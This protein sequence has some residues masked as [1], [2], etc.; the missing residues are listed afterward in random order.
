M[1]D[2][3]ARAGVDKATVSRALN[4]ETRHHVSAATASRVE[5]AAR[6]LGYVPNMLAR[7]LRR[8]ASMTVGVLLPDI[9]NPI[10]P[11]IVRGIESQLSPRH[12]TAL[13]TNTDGR[14]DLEHAA[15][16]SLLARRVDGFL[17]ATGRVGG[18][19]AHE[20]WE[21]RIPAI[22]VNRG[23]P[24]VPYPVVTGADA[25]GVVDTVDHL[26]QLGHRRLLHVAGPADLT[27]SAIR[28]TA[29]LAACAARGVVA[30]VVEAEAISIPA[31]E[32]LAARE[33]DHP[34]GA[35]A[36]VTANDLLA[37]GVLRVMRSRGLE[38]P[39]DLSVTGFNDNP[40]AEDAFV[41]LTTVRVPFHTMGARAAGML[42]ERIHGTAEL[43]A[44][45]TT[46]P[47][48][49]VIRGS[50]GPAPEIRPR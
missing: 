35:T 15:Y 1:S 24:G 42:V 12:Y 43:S 22:L 28:R 36:I 49:L 33:L 46:L 27:T 17:I 37:L 18:R 13:V 41:P 21:Q 4:A 47:V 23:V 8:S 34:S 6:E 38:C 7:G 25:D 39:R 44:P 31:G 19:V 40:F 50:T 2:V 11:P 26:V 48:S 16:S 5:S 3:A 29:F 14:D 9:T 32:R 30:E 10:F 20:A 45:T